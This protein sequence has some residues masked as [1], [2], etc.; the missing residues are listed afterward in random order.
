M[1]AFEG[2]IKQLPPMFSALKYHGKPLYKL[3]RKGI[4]LERR[5]REIEIKSIQVMGINL[6]YC[7][8]KVSCSKGTYIRTLCAEIGK[9]LS[10]GAHMIQL[11]RT[12][13]GPFTLN[14]AISLEE[15]ETRIKSGTIQEKIISLSEA[16]PDFSSLV[17]GTDL[18]EKVRKRIKIVPHDLSAIF[19]PLLRTGEKVKIL[20]PEGKL[21]AV[22][23]LL[24][25]TPIVDFSEGKG[26]FKLS[27][28]FVS[29]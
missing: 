19:L 21:F 11:K 14:N 28:V 13:S 27:R 16:L 5:E 25:D 24:M 26:V 8:F 4:Y 6:P 1:K 17:F 3:A 12:K 7:S 23:E 9:K 22:A 29:Q 15:A 10:C 18:L 2:K 20:S